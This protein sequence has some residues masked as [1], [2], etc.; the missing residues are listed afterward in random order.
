MFK[1]ALLGRD[2]SYT[3]SPSVHSAIALS[4]GERIQFDIADVQYDMLGEAVQKQIDGY[5][6]FF[7]TKPYKTDVKK[8][9]ACDAYGAINVVRCMDRATFN[10][11]GAGFIR[12]LDIN[13]S[14]WR[15]DVNGALILGAGGAA[16]SVARELCALG[17]RVYVLNR[18][19][20]HALKLCTQCRGAELYVNQPAELIVNCTSLGFNGE[21]VLREL[22]VLPDF[23]YAFDLVYGAGNT[24][25]LYRCGA[26]GARTANGKDMLILQAIEGDKILLGR[27]WD[28][29][30]VFSKV[31]DILEN[32]GA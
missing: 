28:V 2:I 22:C 32:Q 3:Q 21:D 18:T 29:M 13:F 26:D 4:T 1:L 31:R 24:P 5:D 16:Y 19:L 14:E 20:K 10:T 6:G 17:K 15:G 11:D 12:A 23:K 25:F 7:V 30:S 9:I 8:Y 27:D